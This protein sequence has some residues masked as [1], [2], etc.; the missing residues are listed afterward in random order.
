[1]TLPPDLSQLTHEEKDALILAQAALIAALEARLAELERR[2]GLT[3]KNSGKPPSSDGLG[4][5]PRTQSQRGRDGKKK[6][7]G[8]QKGHPGTT[9]KQVKTPDVRIDHYPDTCSGCGAGL[10]P[11][12]DTGHAA[13]QV[14]DLPEPRPLV[15]TEHLAHRCRCAGCGIETRA[16]FPDGV[17]APVQYGGRISAIAVYLQNY[18]LLPED[19]LAELMIDLFGVPLVPATIAR[20]AGSCAARYQGL[21]DAIEN[22]IKTVPIKHM[23]ETG[24]RIGGKT[25][26]LHIAST[27]WLTHYRTS[28]KRGSLLGGVSGIIVRELQALIDIEKECWAGQMQKLLRIALHVVN[29]AKLNGV[30]PSPRHVARLERCYDAIVAAGFAFHEGQ[31]P[32]AIAMTKSGRPRRGRPPRRTGHNLLIRLRDR[33]G[34]VLRFL[35]DP[36]VPFTNNQGEQD[37]RMMKLRQKIS[38][39]FRSDEGA[40]IFATLRSLISTAKKHG[41]NILQVLTAGPEILLG[42]LRPA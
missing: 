15:V 14:F 19:R 25:Q 33:R 9:L 18:Q 35:H 16:S 23:D 6:P 7:S 24:F 11:T 3:S 10:T 36:D 21:V 37:G 39:G 41:W 29:R 31:P 12:M 8:G 5:P 32:L 42:Q 40:D 1:M 27:E 28:D 26:W 22:R 2:I 30:A 4:K 38:G 20:M 34:D 17:T 13:R